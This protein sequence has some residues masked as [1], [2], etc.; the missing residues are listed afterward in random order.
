VFL[1]L[2]KPQ[3]VTSGNI[4]SIYSNSTNIYSNSTYRCAGAERLMVV[5]LE[6]FLQWFGSRAENTLSQ[7]FST[8][9]M[10]RPVLQT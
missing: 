4:Y 8:F 1:K 3:F 5:N 6:F 10:Q 2:S 7:W 9:F